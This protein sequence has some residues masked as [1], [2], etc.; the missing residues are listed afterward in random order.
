MESLPQ[1]RK[2][3]GYRAVPQIV[4]RGHN[5]VRVCQVEPIQFVQHVTERLQ[6]IRIVHVVEDATR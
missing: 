5:H 2:G 4:F 6:R 1:C 3:Y